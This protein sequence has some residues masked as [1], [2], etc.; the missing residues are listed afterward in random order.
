MK[1]ATKLL[2]ILGGGGLGPE[3]VVNGG[4]DADTNW[5]KGTGWTIAAGVA[6]KVAGSGSSL[7]QTP[8]I[9]VSG[10]RYQV[11]C[12]VSN[13]VAG[14]L[15][16][17]LGSSSVPLSITA[18]GTYTASGVADAVTFQFFGTNLFAG[19]LDNVSCRQML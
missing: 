16:V 2:T 19:D 17:I 8:N 6:N 14:T 3:L 1:L 7:T 13:Y 11:T 9:L 15:S 4:F 18:N 10:R 12:T 5:T